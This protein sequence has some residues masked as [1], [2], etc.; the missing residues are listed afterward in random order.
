MEAPW[1]WPVSSTAW[2]R[3][4]WGRRVSFLGPGPTRY[5]GSSRTVAIPAKG[6]SS[7][8]IPYSHTIP[9]NVYIW[10]PISRASLNSDLMPTFTWL[11]GAD[12]ISIPG[13]RR[14]SYFQETEGICTVCE[15]LLAAKGFPCHSAI[16]SSQI[17]C[18]E[19]VA[20]S[21]HQEVGESAWD[22]SLVA[23]CILLLKRKVVFVCLVLDFCF[24]RIHKYL[25]S[26]CTPRSE[27]YFC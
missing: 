19:D 12:Y 8:S 14:W 3:F 10:G 2:D 25:L 17:P 13:S 7:P 21:T 23:T 5:S 27:Q 20:V 18:E 22:R 26:D 1:H 16:K 15:H 4:G 6:I 11:P 24:G 9:T